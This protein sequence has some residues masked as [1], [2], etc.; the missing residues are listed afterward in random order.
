MVTPCTYL[1]PLV[2]AYQMHLKVPPPATSSSAY[3]SPWQQETPPS[4]LPLGSIP[5]HSHMRLPL[6]LGGG[7]VGHY[8]MRNVVPGLP[9]VDAGGYGGHRHAVPV[10]IPPQPWSAP[11]PSVYAGICSP[12]PAS[13][14][15]APPCLPQSA[16]PYPGGHQL[17]PIP[18]PQHRGLDLS[19]VPVTDRGEGDGQRSL[20]PQIKPVRGP[21]GQLQSGGTKPTAFPAALELQRG[22]ASPL[23]QMVSFGSAPSEEVVSTS[24]AAENTTSFQGGASLGLGMPVQSNLPAEEWHPEAEYGDTDLR[25]G[26][27]YYNRSFKAGGRRGQEDRGGAFRGRSSRGRRD[28]AGRGN[29]GYTRGRGRGYFQHSNARE[30]G[31]TS[32]QFAPA[33]ET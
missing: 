15:S 8:E 18:P 31:Y 20:T 30:A 14:Y 21:G 19:M 12:T 33:A 32:G 13:Q 25:S 29:R 3:N 11:P 2:H 23:V 7:P 17:P 4:M 9:A 6:G 1:A 16:Q 26:R 22:G 10:H 5:Y 28:Y 24:L 27:S